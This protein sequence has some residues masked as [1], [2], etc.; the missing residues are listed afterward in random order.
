MIIG[1]GLIF[2]GLFCISFEAAPLLKLLSHVPKSDT[3]LTS[4]FQMHRVA[5]RQTHKQTN[6][7]TY[8]Q[9]HTQ[10]NSRHHLTLRSHQC[11]GQKEKANFNASSTPKVTNAI[12]VILQVLCNISI[13]L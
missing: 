10:T 9:T 13:K 6:T 4:G 2:Y 1:K 3:C 7:H 5:N 8:S 11:T 12:K